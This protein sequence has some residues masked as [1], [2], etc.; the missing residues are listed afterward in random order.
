MEQLDAIRINFNQDEIFLLNISLAF[1][2]FGVAL[3]LKKDDFLELLKNPRSILVGLSSQVL[4]LPILTIA[5][6]HILPVTRGVAMGM[7]LVASCP[8]GNISNF[9]SSWARA[10]ATLSVSLTSIVTMASAFI[11]PVSF[12]FWAMFLPQSGIEAG[13]INV[14]LIDMLKTVSMIILIPL[15]AGIAFQRYFPKITNKIK[16][17]ISIISVL[18]LITFIAVALGNNTDYLLGTLKLTL[19]IVIIHNAL[20]Y[21][22][23]YWY[24]RLLKES[25]YNARAISLETG[26]QNSGLGLVLIFNFFPDEGA[27]MIIAAWWGIW[28]IFSA[29]V[30]A[31]YWR[32]RPVAENK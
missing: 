8:G 25:K 30:L 4:L 29:L 15:V 24:S 20:G 31:S 12:F 7:L 13:S 22:G 18:L 11:T 17:P 9:A 32:R 10:N 2:M 28:D 19:W 1:I 23:G 21:L 6:I 3:F 27:M 26:I 5:L 14:S 16:S